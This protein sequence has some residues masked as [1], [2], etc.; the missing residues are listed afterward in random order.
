MTLGS[1]QCLF[2]VMIL[3]GIGDNILWYQLSYFVVLVM[4]FCGVD[5]DIDPV[6]RCKSFRFLGEV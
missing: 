4:I 1:L 3:C 6:S 2:K 5:D